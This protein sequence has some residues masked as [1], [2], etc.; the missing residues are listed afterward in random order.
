MTS[1]KPSQG[2]IH[3]EIANS[4]ITLV[5]AHLDYV[6]LCAL[7][8]EQSPRQNFIDLLITW[9]GVQPGF[10]ERTIRLATRHATTSLLRCLIMGIIH[11]KVIPGPTTMR[12]VLDVLPTTSILRPAQ[13]NMIVNPEITVDVMDQEDLANTLAAFLGPRH[14]IADHVLTQRLRSL[15]IE[16]LREALV[17]YNEEHCLYH[18]PGAVGQILQQLRALAASRS[19]SNNAGKQ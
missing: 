4:I 1:G 5:L 15:P 18:V 17:Y 14:G 16:T 12:A 9:R 10:Y 11:E 8:V 19:T 7:V 3:S 6:G 2:S 13:V